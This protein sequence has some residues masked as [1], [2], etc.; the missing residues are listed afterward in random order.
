MATGGY[1]NGSAT[2]YPNHGVLRSAKSGITVAMVLNMATVVIMATVALSLFVWSM[3]DPDLAH[4]PPALARGQQAENILADLL[5]GAGWRVRR[6]AKDAADMVVRRRGIEY[7]VEV[8]SASEGRVDRLIPLWSQAWLQASR[9]A[10]GKKP[11]LAVI[12]APRISRRAAEQVLAFASEYAPAAAA[13]VIDFAGLRLFHGAQLEGLNSDD[14]DVAPVA[15][16]A[17]DD[18]GDLFS[19]LNQWMLKVLLA[20]ELPERLLSA[21]RDR[22]RNASKLAVAAQVSVMSAFRLVQQLGREGFLHE[23]SGYLAL[24]RRPEL[25]RRWQAS[26]SR[27]VAEVPMRFLIRGS[28]APVELRRMLQGG[29]ACLGLFAAAEA[30]HFGFVR[31]VP[32]HVYVPRVQ[33]PVASWKNVVPVEGNEPPNVI[34]RQASAPQSVFRALVHA[35]G[36]PV[37]D[38]LQVWLD[39]SSHPARGQEQADLIRSKVLKPIIDGEPRRGR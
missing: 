18:Q 23:S 29:H 28:K 5:A 1:S 33:S 20:P 32:P 39:V 30:L 14:A 13:G 8:K 34:V 11:A 22:Y 9:A 36:V 37:S 21:P 31:G 19:D 26:A 2:A 16:S 17:H 15:R 3:I 4:R 6:E 24:V 12:A 25:F 10:G 27:R 38:I 35:D 7:V